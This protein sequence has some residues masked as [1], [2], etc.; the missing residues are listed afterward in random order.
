MLLGH[1]RLDNTQAAIVLEIVQLAAGAQPGDDPAEHAT[2]QA[3]AQRVGAI[4]GMKPGELFADPQIAG[5]EARSA[6]LRLLASRLETRG[7]RELT[8]ALAFLVS[9]AD[10]QLTPAEKSA[11]DAFQHALGLDY[12]RATDM[13]VLVSNIVAAEDAVTGA[14]L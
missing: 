10:L 3:V 8:Y 4:V 7:T 12:R 5:E 11:L 13:V 14:Q 9:V 6:Y 2:L 1:E